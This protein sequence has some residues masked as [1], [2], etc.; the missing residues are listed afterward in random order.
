M[1][2][3]VVAWQIDEKKKKFVPLSVAGLRC[4]RSGIITADGGK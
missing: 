3:A 4:D 2:Q 1:L